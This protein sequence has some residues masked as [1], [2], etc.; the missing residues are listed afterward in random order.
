MKR[1]LNPS[2]YSSAAVWENLDRNRPIYSLSTELIP[3]YEWVD[4]KPTKKIDAYKAGFTQEGAEYFQVK[5]AKK[6][7]LPKYMSVVSFDNITA[8]ETR[9]DVYF[10]ADD[11]K[12]VK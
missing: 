10:K 2:G 7:E 11:V 8:Y 3:Q 4:G 6:V 12:E 9:Y 5:F 1:K